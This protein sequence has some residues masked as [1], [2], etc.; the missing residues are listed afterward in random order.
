MKKGYKQL[1]AFFEENRIEYVRTNAKGREFYSHPACGEIGVNPGVDERAVK[2]IIQ[3]VQK[4]LGLQTVK[5]QAKRNAAHIKDRQ[6]AERARLAAEIGKHRGEIADLLS[7]R[8]RQLG[9][10]GATLTPGQITAISRLIEKHER[11]I[12]EM[13]KLMQELPE[14]NAHAGNGRAQH[15]S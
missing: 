14:N 8:E 11:E 12:R 4:S 15:R 13:Q 1:A 2:Q 5:D 3:S 9:G 10:L 7:Q 6:A